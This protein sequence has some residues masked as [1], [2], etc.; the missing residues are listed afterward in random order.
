MLLIGTL[1][2]MYLLC[3]VWDKVIDKTNPFWIANLI[4]TGL[5]LWGIIIFEIVA[6]L[7][8]QYQ[9]GLI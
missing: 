9:T 5:L 3:N 4:P 1:L 7:Y 6:H 2:A 8:V